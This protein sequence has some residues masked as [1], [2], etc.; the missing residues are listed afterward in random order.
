MLYHHIIYKWQILL[1]FD[2]VEDV[3]PHNSMQQHIIFGKGYCQ[4]AAGIA[5]TVM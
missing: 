2:V 4:V 5:T 3:I 1:P